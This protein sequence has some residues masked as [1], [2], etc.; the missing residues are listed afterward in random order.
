MAEQFNASSIALL[1]VALIGGWVLV[2]ALIDLTA[3]SVWDWVDERGSRARAMRDLDHP[4]DALSAP[5]QE[6]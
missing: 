4:V 1:F 5:P 3:R 6:R 2:N